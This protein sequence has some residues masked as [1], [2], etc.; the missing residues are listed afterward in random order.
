M[1]LFGL[2][3][4][5]PAE[6]PAAPGIRESLEDLS[7]FAALRVEVTD[8]QGRLLFIGRLLEPQ[9]DR[10]ELHQITEASISQ[11]TEP[12][13]VRLTGEAEAAEDDE[14]TLP[15]HLRG[16]S[17]KAAK[18]I[19]MEGVISPKG[20]RSW[21]VEKLVLVRAENERAF[22]RM[23]TNLAGELLPVDPSDGWVEI[24]RLQNISVGGAQIS[25]NRAFSEGERLMLR[26]QLLPDRPS[27]ALPCE[28]LR[29]LPSEDGRFTYGCKFVEMHES[30]QDKITRIIFELQRKNLNRPAFS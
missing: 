19:R 5:K 12:L 2:F 8:A 14:E 21:Q 30:E 24:C 29:A 20:V 4:K 17:G 1:G 28:I 9:Y 22:F 25:T 15:V 11:D 23:E 7:V 27:M 18:A 13:A 6:Q 26:V 16:Y 3:K 10:A